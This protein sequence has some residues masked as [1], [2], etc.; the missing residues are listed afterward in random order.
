[1][2]HWL[3][4]YWELFL[5]FGWL[6]IWLMLIWMVIFF[7]YRSADKCELLLVIV[8]SI[9]YNIH[10]QNRFQCFMV[11]IKVPITHSCHQKITKS[12]SLFIFLSYFCFVCRTL[13]HSLFWRKL[14]AIG[15]V[16]YSPADCKLESSSY[17]FRHPVYLTQS[18]A[19]HVSLPTL[20]FFLLA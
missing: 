17:S 10:N 7:I 15:K 5:L 3:W 4:E 2:H 13:L 19:S 8:L 12:N 6:H 9:I 14:K 20:F 18:Q 16:F 11:K 1:M